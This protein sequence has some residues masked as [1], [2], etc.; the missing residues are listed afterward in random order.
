MQACQMNCYL[1]NH[2]LCCFVVVFALLSTFSY[3]LAPP[4]RDQTYAVG[5]GFVGSMHLEAMVRVLGYTDLPLVV[6]TIIEHMR[7]KA[8]IRKCA[9]SFGRCSSFVLRKQ[10][11]GG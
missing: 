5:R 11:C 10:V 4:L 1:W 2:A 8:S 3:V 6:E 7:Q 9:T